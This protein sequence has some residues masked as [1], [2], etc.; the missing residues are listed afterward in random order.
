ML[1][2][3]T[4]LQLLEQLDDV[5]LRE[6][7]GDGLALRFGKLCLQPPQLL[8]DCGQGGGEQTRTQRREDVLGVS[9]ECPLRIE[10]GLSRGAPRGGDGVNVEQ[11]ED[12]DVALDVGAL[13]VEQHAAALVEQLGEEPLGQVVV[14]V[15][16]NVAHQI[17]NA[18]GRHADCG[19]AQHRVS[20]SMRM[21]SPSP[22]SPFFAIVVC[23]IT[24][25]T[26]IIIITII[27]FLLLFLLPS[28]MVI[29]VI[30][31]TSCSPSSLAWMLMT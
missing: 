24:V 3:M 26:I 11:I 2:T 22:S 23:N 28:V 21:S 25:I 5:A 31:I 20:R 4:D 13:E 1:V 12:F 18:H 10:L 9:G 15:E 14:L 17:A 8:H 7:C 30:I 19:K 16:L 29:T 27:L 6:P